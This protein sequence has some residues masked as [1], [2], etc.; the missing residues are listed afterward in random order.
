MAVFSQ[1]R[2]LILTPVLLIASLQQFVTLGMISQL[3]CLKCAD[4]AVFHGLSVSGQGANQNFP[5]REASTDLIG[6][7]NNVFT[8]CQASGTARQTAF[9]TQ[10]DITDNTQ[11]GL[12]EAAFNTCLTNASPEALQIQTTSLQDTSLTTTV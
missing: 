8:I 12:I 1:T 7:T 3:T 11:E 9:N 2:L 5:Q 10:V 4:L 6:A